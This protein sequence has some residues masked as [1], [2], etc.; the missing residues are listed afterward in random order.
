MPDIVKIMPK[1]QSP[2]RLANPRVV[3]VAYD[4]LCTFEFGCAVE[5]FG[6]PRP[7][8]GETWYR[9]AVA[10]A[11]QGPLRATGGI[12][13]MAD[14]G[15]ALLEGAG[16]VIVPGWRGIDSPVPPEL[17]MALRQAHAAG[18]RVLSLCSGAFV[19]AAAGLLDGRRVTTHW[20]Y[21]DELVRRYPRLR[22]VADV[23][24][25]DEGRVLTAAG[26]AAGL[27]LCLHL[28]RRDFGP[29][30]ANQ[31]ARRLV[32]P[33]HRQGGQAQYVERPVPRER[34]AGA[35]LAPLLDQVRASLDQPWPVERLAAE[36]AIS[37]RG[38]H[39][40]FHESVGQSPGSWLAAERVMRA[41]ELL[42]GSALP[43]EEVAA[44]CGFG[45]A[46]TLRHHFRTTL[47]VSPVDYRARFTVAP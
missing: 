15:L 34:A 32:I 30:V 25:V 29:Q 21:A 19:L 9:F 45:S 28:V 8:M 2:G 41:R 35:R 14:G 23:L 17:V 47:G 38:L 42:E 6:L 10:S 7:E 33:A 39:R 12:K 16:T 11:D 27:D 22:F 20:R 3:A 37:I 44:A 5:V 43:I 24:Y 13:V 1:L 4:G 18:A 36:A 40:R 26:S 46:A 31:I